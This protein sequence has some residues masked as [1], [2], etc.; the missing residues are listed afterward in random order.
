M[1][2]PAPVSFL[3]LAAALLPCSQGAAQAELPCHP[4]LD[5]AVQFT[6]P[7]CQGVL[8]DALSTTRAEDCPPPGT[9]IAA[10]LKDNIREFFSVIGRDTC[11]AELFGDGDGVPHPRPCLPAVGNVVELRLWAVSEVDT[12][13]YPGLSTKEQDCPLP[14]TLPE[15]PPAVDK[16]NSTG[17][18]SSAARL[19]GHSRWP[20]ALL[21]AASLNAFVT[22]Q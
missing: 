6:C 3:L 10:C 5:A 11:W 2:R 12:H 1:R 4:Y 20:V 18:P 14:G 16:F 15:V 17:A 9:P 19:S 13:L 22:I 8:R 7:Y 21:M